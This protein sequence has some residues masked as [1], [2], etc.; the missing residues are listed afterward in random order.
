MV[1][2]VPAIPFTKEIQQQKRT[3]PGSI[4]QRKTW[5]I[6]IWPLLRIKKAQACRISPIGIAMR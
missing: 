1:L 4:Y 2:L 3:C 5:C 6:S